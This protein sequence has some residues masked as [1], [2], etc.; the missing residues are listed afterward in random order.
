MSRRTIGKRPMRVLWFADSMKTAAEDAQMG[1]FMKAADPFRLS[2][3]LLVLSPKV[4]SR[5][6]AEVRAQGGSVCTANALSREDIGAFLRVW[7]CI[8]GGKYDLIHTHTSWASLWGMAAERLLGVP[9]V[10]TLYDTRVGKSQKT[11]VWKEQQRAIRALR[12]RAARVCALSG[13]QW[14]RYVQERTFSR[15]FLEL[16]YQGVEASETPMR[17]EEK[18][19][20]QIWLRGNAG[21]PPGGQIAVTI[22]DLDDWESGVD[23]LLWAIPTIAEAVPQ[24]RF[25]IVGEG[26][27]KSEL[28]RRVRARGF[29]KIVSWH[30]LDDDIHQ[31][32]AGSDLFVHPSLRDP[33][34]AAALRAMA[35][36]LPVVGTRVGGVPEIIG[37]SEVGRL[38]PRSDSDALAEAVVELFQ[39]P[40]RLAVMGRAAYDRTRKL[41]P[42]S[43]WVDK[44]ERMYRDVVEEARRGGTSRPKSYARLDV[45]LLGLS[46]SGRSNGSRH[47]RA[48]IPVR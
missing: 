36:G 37:T 23:V 22:A 18:E 33:F 12:R 14:D 4:D 42:V 48:R 29:N 13:A 8:R 30:G 7:R 41:F 16:I 32:L 25:V 9:V 47:T 21:F 2:L 44:V 35:V 40:P 11:R 43:G 46:G 28:E 27:H 1:A 39:D 15:T 20:S 5:F 24:A 17:T 10:A 26:E 19:A 6:G 3:D 34:P 31:I 38:V 45:K